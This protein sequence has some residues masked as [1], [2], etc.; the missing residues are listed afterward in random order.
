MTVRAPKYTREDAIRGVQEWAEEYGR[1]PSASAWARARRRPHLWDINTL[2]GSWNA[3]I[4][5]AGFEPVSGGKTV[6]ARDLERD[7]AAV[8]KL[9]AGIGC[10]RQDVFAAAVA[11]VLRADPEEVAA[12]VATL[13]TVP[14]ERRRLIAR[15]D[16]PHLRRS[17]DAAKHEQR[18][19]RA[20]RPAGDE[21]ARESPLRRSG[22]DQRTHR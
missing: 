3:L 17:R 1:Q 6:K 2:F 5:A 7:L 13:P 21:T 8:D 15:L 12:I 20:S 10:E 22:H 9:A 4:E 16:S 18:K 19:K 14:N 11:L